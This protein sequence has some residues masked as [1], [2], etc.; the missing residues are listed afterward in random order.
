MRGRLT[1]ITYVVELGVIVFEK[2]G[3]ILILTN[4]W[5]EGTCA[6]FDIV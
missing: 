4:F 1:E 2:H 5:R 6:E 3:L